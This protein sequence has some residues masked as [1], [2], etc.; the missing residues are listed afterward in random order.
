MHYSR[1]ADEPKALEMLRILERAWDVQ[2]DQLGFSAPLDDG[3]ACGPDGRYDVFFWRGVDGAY[4]DSV[5]EH[6]ATPHDDYSTYMAIDAAGEY[7]GALL[8]TTLAHEFNHAVQASDDWWESALI[9][10]MGATF[11][12]TLVYPEQDDWFYVMEDF[13]ARPEWSLFHDDRYR[14]WYMYGAAMYLHF[15]YERH[16][17]DDPAFIARV[18]RASRS[19]PESGR[20]DYI[21]ALRSVLLTERG[22][23]LDDTVVEFMQWRWF[24]AGQDDGAHFA[25]GGDWPSA[26]AHIELDAAEPSFEVEVAAMPYGASY[27]RLDNDSP[28]DRGFTV[29]VESADPYVEWRL[30]TAGGEAV[31][32]SIE[33]PP[34]SAPVLVAVALPAAEQSAGTLDF[35]SRTMVVRLVEL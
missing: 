16:F 24:V 2:V 14:T 13:Q 15:L 27:I 1:F 7:G 6:P 32:G 18:W 3:G 30:T 20:P 12:E 23:S 10:E 33:V 11:V 9:F 4:V 19:D 29:T 21:D 28:A 35:E 17:A 22:V 8:D 34:A 25:R 31:A 26:V 5:A